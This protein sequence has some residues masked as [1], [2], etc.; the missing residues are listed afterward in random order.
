MHSPRT[1]GNHGFCVICIYN[2]SGFDLDSIE[3][4]NKLIDS[5]AP[6]FWSFNNPSSFMLYF[7]EIRS[8][9]ATS[10]RSD[11]SKLCVHDKKFG[12]VSVGSAEGSLIASFD[13]TERLLAEPI[14]TIAN[15]AIIRACGKS[16]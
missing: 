16:R 2:E 14:G 1:T 3:V 11:L 13:E 7:R 5:V 6:D 10:F 9:L 15:E 8:D 4:L 12:E